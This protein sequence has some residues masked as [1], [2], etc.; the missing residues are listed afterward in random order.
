M[1]S[2][3]LNSDL[4]PTTLSSILSHPLEHDEAKILG[5]YSNQDLNVF[6]RWDPIT[7]ILEHKTENANFAS[8]SARLIGRD[9]TTQ[10]TWL[11]M[12]RFIIAL[13]HKAVNG[14][15]DS[16][17]REQFKAMASSLSVQKGTTTAEDFDALY[18]ETVAHLFD[19]NASFLLS[20][21]EVCYILLL[22]WYLLRSGWYRG[23]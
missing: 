21:Q 23:C 7:G 4:Q 22:A 1:I 14:Q 11:R 3:I 15:D 16:A 20:H 18:V 5:L 2:T 8:T 17:L 10:L 13:L 12:R 6:D 19:A 9:R